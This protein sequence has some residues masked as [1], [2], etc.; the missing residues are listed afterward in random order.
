MTFAKDF[1]ALNFLESRIRVVLHLRRLARVES[2]LE[3]RG[4][5]CR[6]RYGGNNSAGGREGRRVLASATSTDV[7]APFAR[8]T[9]RRE[10]VPTGG[11][12]RDGRSRAGET[13]IPRREGERGAPRE[14]AGHQVEHPC[15]VH[16]I[17]IPGDIQERERENLAFGLFRHASREEYADAREG[18]G[19][20]W[21]RRAVS[22]S[23]LHGQG[24]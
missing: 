15:I 12:G 24:P 4:A 6:S 8:V 1:S 20:R 22:A 5:I 19:G 14:R 16:A 2:M 11:G 21:R 9:P 18:G 13:G 10:F 23:R 3:E 7:S 17:P